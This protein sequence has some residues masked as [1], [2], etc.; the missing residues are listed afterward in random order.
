[1]AMLWRRDCHVFE[2]LDFQHKIC[3][4]LEIIPSFSKSV[5]RNLG[6]IINPYL[7]NSEMRS[8]LLCS[9]GVEEKSANT[10]CLQLTNFWC[11]LVPSCALNMIRATTH[12]LLLLL[13]HL[14]LH[15]LLPPMPESGGFCRASSC[16]GCEKFVAK[17]ASKWK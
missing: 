15:H 13:L 7:P 17:E 6:Q 9:S 1:M 2:Y 11:Q 14:H 10:L 16:T 8:Q 4:C 12:L 3:T 5:C